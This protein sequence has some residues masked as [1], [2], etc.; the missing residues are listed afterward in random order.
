MLAIIPSRKNSKTI[1]QKSFK[2]IGNN[3]L[4]EKTI[5]EA[6]K[7]KKIS[8]ILVT[9]DDESVLSIAKKNKVDFII[10]RSK[11]LS[12]DTST[13]DEYLFDV[14][15]YIKKKKLTFKDFIL[16]Q[17]TSPLRTCKDIDKA[18]LFFKKKKL[19]NLISVT[20]PIQDPSEMI[21]VKNKKIVFV[22]N[23]KKNRKF[24]NKL[25]QSYYETYFIDGSIYIICIKLFEKT[26]KLIQKN[27]SLY[28]LDKLKG[29][30][31]NDSSDLKLA[32]ALFK[33]REH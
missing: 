31:I 3:T 15:K 21:F 25:R 10:N 33:L 9:S 12:K 2:K 4:I 8:N 30:D 6:K 13:A 22:H 11:K 14:C 32:N 7:S 20:K 26:K 1:K 16:L 24:K 27:A 23:K 5:F 29:I 17:P 18:I 19:K 28:E